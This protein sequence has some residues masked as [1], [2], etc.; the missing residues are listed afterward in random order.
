[1]SDSRPSFLT[2]PLYNFFSPIRASNLQGIISDAIG[3]RGYISSVN[4]IGIP[5]NVLCVGVEE[6]GLMNYF[7]NEIFR[8]LKS[9]TGYLEGASQMQFVEVSITVSA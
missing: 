4:G 7:S 2:G 9:S 6:G 8:D 1:M 3:K 5:E